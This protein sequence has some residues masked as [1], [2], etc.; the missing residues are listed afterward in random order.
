MIPAQMMTGDL[1]RLKRPA[2]VQK[3]EH[4]KRSVEDALE[5]DMPPKKMQITAA[6][7][8]TGDLARLQRLSNVQKREDMKRKVSEEDTLPERKQAKLTVDVVAANA[9]WTNGTASPLYSPKSPV[10]SPTYPA[11]SPTSP[12]YSPLLR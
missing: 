12:S 4:L 9:R 3:R 1:A 11:Y 5:E 2:N 8:M 6:Q 7:M 10:Y